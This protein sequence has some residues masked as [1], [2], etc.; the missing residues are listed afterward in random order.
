LAPVIQHSFIVTSEPKGERPFQ[1]KNRP[2]PKI[3]LIIN[4]QGWLFS[5]VW[6]TEQREENGKTLLI[7]RLNW[8]RPKVG[9]PAAI[10]MINHI[11]NRYHPEGEIVQIEQI[12]TA[13]AQLW[14]FFL[15][16][17]QEQYPQE[18]S[19]TLAGIRELAI[20]LLNVRDNHK[21]RA[22]DQ[23]LKVAGSKGQD[24]L[25]RIN[26]SALAA[27]LISAITNLDQRLES[28]AL[29]SADY[30][31]RL[32]ALQSMRRFYLSR[33]AQIAEGVEALL[34]DQD[35]SNETPVDHQLAKRVRIKANTLKAISNKVKV[36]PYQTVAIHL[37]CQLNSIIAYLNEMELDQGIDLR[38]EI[39]KVLANLLDYLKIP[40]IKFPDAQ[41]RINDLLTQ[42]IFLQTG[43]ID[44]E[45][46]GKL[47][48]GIT[49][50]LAD[51]YHAF[52]EEPYSSVA[53]DSAL[54]L[55]EAAISLQKGNLDR[56]KEKIETALS[57]I[58][59]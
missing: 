2:S 28:I 33:L 17:N 31:M 8:R 36:Q 46:P 21:L 3:N 50:C 38:P 19:E 32:Q 16:Y 45:Q 52:P 54:A 30:A 42:A 20:L 35:L 4:D 26:P 14:Q 9:I 15:N 49:K 58:D 48:R 34:I 55:E 40:E 27:R 10:R 39:R 11:L 1:K 5:P 29:I 6:E 59:W 41:E 43:Q 44:K 51:F 56:T 23:F 7:H 37:R 53:T 22:L 25:G 47:R 18:I 57:R 24:S 13:A 12:S